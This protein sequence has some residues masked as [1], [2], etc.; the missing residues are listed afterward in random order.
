MSLANDRI[1]RIGIQVR[2]AHCSLSHSEALTAQSVSY[3]T[4][5]ES[6]NTQRRVR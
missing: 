3:F 4:A 6:P 2:R 1:A 5:I